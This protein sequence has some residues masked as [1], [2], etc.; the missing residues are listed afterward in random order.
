M[1]T[2]EMYI[3]YLLCN[4]IIHQSECAILFS[5][6]HQLQIPPCQS[7]TNS[8]HSVPIC[9]S[10]ES[11]IPVEYPPSKSPTD[12]SALLGRNSACTNAH[13]VQN[14]GTDTPSHCAH[15]SPGN[16]ERTNASHFEESTPTK[17]ASHSKWTP[18][19]VRHFQI[20]RDPDCPFDQLLHTESASEIRQ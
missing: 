11:G 10:A 12:C 15:S 6:Q 16:S 13:F 9:T 20:E 1:I 19:I 3:D 17:R 14:I 2:T 8:W 7:S 5:C 4:W 18:S